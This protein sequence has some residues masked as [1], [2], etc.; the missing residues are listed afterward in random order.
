MNKKRRSRAIVPPKRQA[1]GRVSPQAR[2]QRALRSLESD[3]Q[4]AFRLENRRI[5]ATEA[6]ISQARLC[7]SSGQWERQ[8]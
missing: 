8:L 7:K 1:V 6:H 3:E 4:R 5:H 2:K